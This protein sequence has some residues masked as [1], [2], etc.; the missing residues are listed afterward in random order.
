MVCDI[1]NQ[2]LN[3]FKRSNCGLE[4]KRE[5]YYKQKILHIW[6]DLKELKSNELRVHNDMILALCT[7]VS[8]Q[9]VFKVSYA[10]L[11][12]NE[13]ILLC[14]CLSVGPPVC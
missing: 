10:P 6:H 2:F 3:R 5:R 4:K 14:F 11:K 9:K 12:R 7:V 13:G 1:L 8:K